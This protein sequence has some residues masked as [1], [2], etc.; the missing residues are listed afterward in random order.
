[1]S[2]FGILAILFAVLALGLTIYKL[3]AKEKTWRFV[4]IPIA[5]SFL[6]FAVCFVLWANKLYA[7][8][9]PSLAIATFLVGALFYGSILAIPWTKNRPNILIYINMGL[10]LAL[11]VALIILGVYL[12]K[13]V[14]QPDTFILVL[15]RVRI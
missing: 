9:Q 5:V 11:G 14:L 3:I 1:M 12:S 10:F 2:P 13:S 7:N 4:Y 8:D 15:S 6:A